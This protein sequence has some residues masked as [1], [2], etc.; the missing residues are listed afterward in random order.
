MT[1]I[2]ALITRYVSDVLSAGRFDKLPE[3]CAPHYKRHLAPGTPPLDLAA[4]CVRL[5]GIRT[6]FPDLELTLHEIVV[7]GDLAAFRATVAGTHEGPLLGLPPTGRKVTTSALD[8]IRVENGKFVDHWG[9]PDLL[10][11]VLGC[12]GAIA[13]K[14]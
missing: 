7:E 13:A 11:L 2:P 3:I 12:G 8:M 14:G 9:G 4:Q 10:T 5:E 1:D 6:A